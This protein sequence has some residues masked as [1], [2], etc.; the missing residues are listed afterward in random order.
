MKEKFS[1]AERHLPGLYVKNADFI[2]IKRVIILIPLYN[3]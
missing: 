3:F 1:T 2:D